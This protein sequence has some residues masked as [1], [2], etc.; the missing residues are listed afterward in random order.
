[1]KFL[2][3]SF[4]T[5]TAQYSG[6]LKKIAGQTRGVAQLGWQADY[7]CLKD[8]AVV[9]VP[10]GAS[11]VPR[12]L[13]RGLRWRAKQRAVTEE[14]C[15]FV[16]RGAYD[17]V[18]IKGFLA[19]P[20]GLRIAS[21]AK[22]VNPACR[23]IYE[24]ATYPYW[25]E[26][27]RYFRDDFKKRDFRSLAGHLL[28]AAQHCAAAP[29]MKRSVD[30]LAVFGQPVERLWGIP[31][32]TIDNG[33]S[34]ERIRL[35][36]R[37]E[38]FSAEQIRLLG[39]AG[40]SVAHGY[41]RVIEGIARYRAEGP[42][43]RPDVFFEIVGENE[44]IRALQAQAAR[45]GVGGRVRF[46][47]YRNAEQLQELYAGCDAAVSTLAAYRLGLR[48]LCPLKSREYCAAGVPFLYA[49][50]DTLPLDAP[51]A[52]KLPNDPSPVN[53]DAVVRFVEN[54]RRHPEISEREREFA[55][56]HYDWKNIMK[57][58]LDFAQAAAV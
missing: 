52:L 8:N 21:R 29:R 44:T 11:P 45:L 41:S 23:V 24:V 18:Y 14:I 57:R 6:I 22:V 56:E 7:L 38:T 1:M 47:G 54:C 28:E 48:W 19:T 34:V 3:V 16:A 40:T 32:V 55:R 5:D 39:V 58:V 15:R 33:I 25:G 53:M 4:V 13:P 12:P 27:R 43:G 35:R 20:Y 31:A 17:A 30:A 26:Y 51:F 42:V 50:E 49:Y 37:P 2:Y 9:L 10:D 46:L 36:G